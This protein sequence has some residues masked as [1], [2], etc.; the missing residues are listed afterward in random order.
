MSDIENPPENLVV[1]KTKKKRNYTPEQ[2]EKMLKNLEKARAA[3]SRSKKKNKEYKDKKRMLAKLKKDKARKAEEEALDAEYNSILGTNQKVS[4]E[5]QEPESSSEEEEP[6]PRRRRK[7]H[8]KKPRKAKKK[9]VRYYYE[10]DDSETS[11]EEW[12]D[13]RT[14]HYSNQPRTR[15]APQRDEVLQQHYNEKMGQIA[16]Q[17]APKQPTITTGMVADM[18]FP[19]SPFGNI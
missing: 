7:K 18:I 6:P 13:E 2:R 3:A 5:V 19:P 8:K 11:S 4:M 15:Q 10:T 9:K 14:H 17:Y 1:K 16:H 12:V